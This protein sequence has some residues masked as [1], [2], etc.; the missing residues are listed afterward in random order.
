MHFDIK[1]LNKL[2]FLYY[3]KQVHTPINPIGSEWASLGISEWPAKIP[4]ALTCMSKTCPLLKILLFCYCILPSDFSSSK[5]L[6]QP[7]ATTEQLNVPF[8]S[9]YITMAVGTMIKKIE[10]I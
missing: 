5:P 8:F 10:G 9:L 4:E 3:L 2:S 1:S 7:L 6:Y